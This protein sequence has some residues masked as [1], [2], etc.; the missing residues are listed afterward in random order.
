[1]LYTQRVADKLSSWI[2]H[3]ID[4]VDEHNTT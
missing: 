2:A 4:L 1:M 3:D